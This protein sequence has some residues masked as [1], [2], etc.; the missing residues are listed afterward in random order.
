MTLFEIRH[1]RAREILSEH[2]RNKLK[3]H[4]L[5]ERTLFDYLVGGAS[6]FRQALVTMENSAFSILLLLKCIS[7]IRAAS[8]STPN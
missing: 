2:G 6:G 3:L 7:I 4:I 8:T 5:G 1:T